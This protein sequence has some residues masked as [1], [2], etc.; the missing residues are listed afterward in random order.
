MN[1]VNLTDGKSLCQGILAEAHTE[2]ERLLLQARQ[3]S[4]AF[5]IKITAIEEKAR[6]ERLDITKQ[7]CTR[8]KDRMLASLPIEIERLRAS[9]IETLLQSIHNE[10]HEQLL[11]RKGFDYLK[12]LITSAAYAIDRMAGT[13]FSVTLSAADFTAFGANLAE[14]IC[15]HTQKKGLQIQVISDPALPE[16]GLFIRD[17]EGRQEWDNRLTARL[18]RLWP[19]LRQ[20]LAD[21]LPLAPVKEIK[22]DSP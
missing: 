11:A 19:E 15:Q 8:R 16:A 10:I 21:I 20:Q 4:E 14:S 6:Q 12:T 17:R 18:E 22:E 3:E 9:R 5:R 13:D 2:A 7:E 1:P